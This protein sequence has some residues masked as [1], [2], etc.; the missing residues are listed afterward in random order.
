MDAPVPDSRPPRESFFKQ[1]LLY[2]TLA[3]AA[4]GA[5]PQYIQVFKAMTWD[6]PVNSV[7]SAEREH[8]LW[9]KN[10][11]CGVGEDLLEAS[12]ADNTRVVA[13]VCPSGDVLVK[14]KRVT[15]EESYR[16]VPLEEAKS[17]DNKLAA[18]IG[19]SSAVAQEVTPAPIRLAQ[20]CQHWLDQ[21]KGILVRRIREGGQCYDETVNTFTGQVVS[22]KPV[23]CDDRC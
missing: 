1:I 4:I 7:N 11:D 23:P 12:L 20:A 13:R 22:R 17:K 2:P 21:A 16:W 3:I 10:V 18:L 14:V 15:G 9:V 19:I 6:V 8:N 5:I